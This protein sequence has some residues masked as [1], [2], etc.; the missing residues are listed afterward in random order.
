MGGNI[1]SITTEIQVYVVGFDVEKIRFFAKIEK[2]PSEV[3][4]TQTKK[5]NTILECDGIDII[6]CSDDIA[7]VGSERGMFTERNPIFK[8]IPPDDTVLC[9]AGKLLFAKKMYIRLKVLI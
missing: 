8:I 2:I 3:G 7:I 9:L 6:D 5:T 1:N 4:P